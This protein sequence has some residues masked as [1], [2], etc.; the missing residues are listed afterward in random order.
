[1]SWSSNNN[2]VA[3]VNNGL[4]QAVNAGTATIKAA[5]LDG[6]GK[7]DSCVVTVADTILVTS[8]TVTP[9]SKTMFVGDADFLEENVQPANATNKEISWESNDPSIVSVNAHSGL[10]TALGVGN[11]TITANALD[12]SG[13]KGTCTVSVQKRILV[14]SL[15]V[16]ATI[17]P[18]Y[19]GKKVGIVATICPENATN[20]SVYWHSDNPNVIE[21]T[22][23]PN[24]NPL[25]RVGNA[26]SAGKA[27]V[28]VRTINQDLV[29]TLPVQ[30]FWDDVIIREDGQYHT[31]EFV[32]G[33]KIWN[34][35]YQD[36]IS[37][38]NVQYSSELTLRT[39]NNLFKNYRGFDELEELH[40]GYQEYDDSQIK[41]I[42]AIDPHGLAKYVNDY[43]DHLADQS[44][45]DKNTRL[46]EKLSYKDHVFKLL[47]NREPQY[48][49]RDD[50]LKWV[51]TNQKDNLT[52]VLSESEFLFGVHPIWDAH[53]TS[54]T[55]FLIVDIL[56]TLVSLGCPAISEG[57]DLINEV[58]KYEITAYFFGID[59]DFPSIVSN[60]VD[61]YLSGVIENAIEQIDVEWVNDIVSVI[62]FHNDL[63]DLENLLNDLPEHYRQP[64]SFCIDQNHFN[65]K[66]VTNKGTK[67]FEE[68]LSILT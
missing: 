29:A 64:L 6:S 10:I 59:I 53:T 25:V 57:M 7:S 1:M 46:Q 49:A 3:T 4:V 23:A 8:I 30:V 68:L 12:G 28:T 22:N 16:N 67:T 52:A 61:N 37:D 14:R 32:K 35:I 33:K 21:L 40:D 62:N 42:Y 27:N 41:L 13:I 48:Y 20:Q 19:V 43:S 66:I 26:V 51:V 2:S 44:N 5:A 50:D 63:E 60:I 31:I 65:V 54:E 38:P 39:K 56:S 47:F 9:S 55:L 58:V 15:S 36:M 24:P 11:A 45:G 18:T 34:C 17:L